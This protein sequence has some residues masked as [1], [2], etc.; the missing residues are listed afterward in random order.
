[1]T[2]VDEIFEKVEKFVNGQGW[3]DDH[4]SRLA[5]HCG[6]LKGEMRVLAIYLNNSEEEIK[7]LQREIVHLK[8]QL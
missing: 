4:R 6:M 5:Y 7:R 8:N 2:D 1:M 3:G